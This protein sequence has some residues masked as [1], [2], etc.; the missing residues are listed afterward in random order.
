MER[1][2]ER[3]VTMTKSDTWAE[4]RVLCKHK[5][6]S[7]QNAEKVAWKERITVD[8]VRSKT[9]SLIEWSKQYSNSDIQ[10]GSFLTKQLFIVTIVNTEYL[11]E[12]IINKEHIAG[13]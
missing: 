4:R 9:Y 2:V 7:K 11:T 3:K 8:L 12:I 6:I 10:F 1:E 5:K 13:T